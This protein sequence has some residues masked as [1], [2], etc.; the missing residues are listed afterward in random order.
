MD[1]DGEL[2]SWIDGQVCLPSKDILVC[3]DK[4]QLESVKAEERKRSAKL[5]LEKTKED[6]DAEGRKDRAVWVPSL[7]EAEEKSLGLGGSFD[8]RSASP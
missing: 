7:D 4:T 6:E 8:G 1:R 3:H 5:S 2:A